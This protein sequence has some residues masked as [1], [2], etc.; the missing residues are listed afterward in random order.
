MSGLL[1]FPDNGAGVPGS[2][3][4]SESN[5]HIQHIARSVNIKPPARRNAPRGTLVQAARHFTRHAGT[6][7]AGVLGRINGS[8][9]QVGTDDGGLGAS[10]RGAA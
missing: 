4:R 2:A 1:P 3:T 5:L 8:G 6:P 10:Q 9:E 7:R